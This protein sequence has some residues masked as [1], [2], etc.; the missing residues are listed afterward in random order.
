MQGEAKKEGK[1]LPSLGFEPRSLGT[2]PPMC[3][4]EQSIVITTCNSA[5]RAGM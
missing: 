1:E 2:T 3:V 5:Y 4:L